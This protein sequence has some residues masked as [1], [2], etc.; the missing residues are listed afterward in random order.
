MNL[1]RTGLIVSD[2]TL[3]YVERWFQRV[4]AADETFHAHQGFAVTGS[5]TF[6]KKFQLEGG[7]A[8]IDYDYGVLTAN[9]VAAWAGFSI[10]GDSYLTGTRAFTRANFKATS[11]IT[12]YGY[13]T[14]VITD[15]PEADMIVNKQGVSGGMTI[16]LKKL[17]SKS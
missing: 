1:A 3:L 5:K 16:D 9:R 4:Q 13:F 7:A 11:G 8:H 14:H 15:A 10:N 6:Y 12:F 17:L 2:C